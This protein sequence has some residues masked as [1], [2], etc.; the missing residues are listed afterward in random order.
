MNHGK[1]MREYPSRE[2]NA[3]KKTRRAKRDAVKIKS[4]VANEAHQ[5]KKKAG[6]KQQFTS[7]NIRGIIR[8]VCGLACRSA[9]HAIQGADARWWDEM[10]FEFDSIALRCHAKET[11]ASAIVKRVADAIRCTTIERGEARER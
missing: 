4:E 8:W 3:K 10:Q 11:D 9:A 5:T 7:A 2:E 6:K 1:G